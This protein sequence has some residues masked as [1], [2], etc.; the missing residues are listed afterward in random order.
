MLKSIGVVAQRPR[1]SR[2]LAAAAG[3]ALGLGLGLTAALPAQAQDTIKV[4][5]LHSLS[6]TMAISET[7]LKD[8]VLM[9]IDEQN[10]KGGVLGKQ[11]E[12]VVVDPASNWP[13]FAEKAK[14]LIRPGQG[15]R[16]LRLLDLG[17]AQVGAA[18][19]RREEQRSSSTPCS[20]RVRRAEQERVLH[21]C[22]AEP[23]GHSCRRV[24]DEQGPVGG[25]AKRWV[26]L[27]TDY[28]Y[29]RTTNKILRYFLHSKGVLKVAPEDIMDQRT[30]RSATATTRPIV[31]DIKK[32][33][34]RR[35]EDGGRL[36][37][38]RRLQ[39][40]VLQGARQR[41]P[42]G[43]GPISGR[44]LLGRRSRSSR[45]LDPKP[46]VGELAAWNYFDV[47]Q[48][49]RSQRLRSSRQWHRLCQGAQ[50]SRA[51]RTSR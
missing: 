19:L 8:V 37:H 27:G 18:G 46:L 20:T 32:F 38:Q 48:G 22:G 2:W 47:D 28:V 36:H 16:R 14:Q 5:I 25:N 30:R 15:R 21:G 35:Q 11:L 34:A 45:G 4:G 26:L 41:R 13:L 23:A 42:E 31:A 3:L 51:T 43:Q 9:L 10:K 33:S 1:G 40:S 50:T 29:P 49:A 44:R 24:P 7:T 12:A 6:G 39:H 17:L